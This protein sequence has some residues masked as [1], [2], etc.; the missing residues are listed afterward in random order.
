MAEVQIKRCIVA[1][2]DW[3]HH[4]PPPPNIP[5]G[6]VAGVFGVGTMQQVAMQRYHEELEAQLREH[7]ET[8]DLVEWAQTVMMWKARSE[9][10]HGKLLELQK[11]LE[12][13]KPCPSKSPTCTKT[14][15]V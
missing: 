7:L 1:N 14:F 3:A 10:A 8:H 6:A 9:A 15:R 4:I 13:E 5:N 2:C 11:E 12:R